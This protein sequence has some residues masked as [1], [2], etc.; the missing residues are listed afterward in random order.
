MKWA[1]ESMH[2]APEAVSKKLKVELADVLSWE[3]GEQAPPVTKLREMA[4]LYKRPVAVFFLSSPPSDFQTIRDYR[5]ISG[6]TGFEVTPKLAYEIRCAHERREIF[7]ELLEELGE[8]PPEF[9]LSCRLDEKPDEVA[10]R[11]RAWLGM[12]L[13]QQHAWT[14]EDIAFKSWRQALE[15]KGLLIFQAEKIDVDLMRGFSICDLPL[16]VIAVNNNDHAHG[17]CFSLFH[18]LTHIA[19]RASGLCNYAEDQ[20]LP[21][22]LRGLEVFCNRVAAAV[23][24]P[25]EALQSEAAVKGH[26]GQ[27][28]SDETLSYLSRRYRV[29]RQAVLLRLLSLDLTTGAFYQTFEQSLRSVKAK[30]KK[31]ESG[32]GP[33]PVTMTISLAGRPYTSI[34]LDS[35]REKRISLNRASDLLGLRVKHFERLTKDLRSR[36][37]RA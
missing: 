15:Q 11:F 16:P 6:L 27:E 22:E 29:S 23:L 7:L 31:K 12:T 35:Y 21:P 37:A 33:H 26:F 9:T 32:G 25:L 18:E 36:E 19:L 14:N 8:K 4:T 17:K 3:S 28:W 1:R 34:I 30:P 10:Q 20:S 13:E 5:H 2:L 24:M